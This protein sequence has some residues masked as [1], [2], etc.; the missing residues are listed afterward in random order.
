MA[1]RQAGTITSS[2]E[3]T[4]SDIAGSAATRGGHADRPPKRARKGND[5]SEKTDG[6]YWN[7]VEAALD[8]LYEEHGE[9]R[10]GT[11][12]KQ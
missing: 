2:V 12:W 9:D 6:K 3:A 11:A 10:T 1:P 5:N 7:W 4:A 8:K